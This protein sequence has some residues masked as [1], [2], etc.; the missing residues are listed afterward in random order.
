[1]GPQYCEGRVCD[2]FYSLP[3]SIPYSSGVIVRPSLHSRSSCQASGEGRGRKGIKSRFSGFLQPVILGTKEKRHVAPHHRSVDTEFLCRRSTLQDGNYFFDK[4][5]H[6]ARRLG[7]FHG[8]YGRVLSRPDPSQISEVSPI[9]C[10]RRSLPIS[11]SSVR[12]FDGSQSFYQTHGDRRRSLTVE[13]VDSSPV[14]RRLAVTSVRSESSVSRPGEELGGDHFFGSPSQ[15][16]EVG[17]GTV[18]G[19]HLCGNEF[20]DTDQQGKSSTAS[21]RETH[22]PGKAG[23]EPITDS[24]SGLP[25][26]SGGAERSSAVCTVGQTVLT[27]HS[28]LSPFA[29]E[30]ECRLLS[31]LDSYSSITTSA[32]GMVVGRREISDRSAPSTSDSVSFSSDRCQSVRMGCAPRTAWSHGLGVLVHPGITGAHQQPRTASSSVI[33]AAIQRP[34]QGTLCASLHGQHH[35]SLI[36]SQTGGDAFLDLVPRI[37]SPVRGMSVF[38]CDSFSQTSP[39]QT[40]CFGGRAFTPSSDPPFGVDPS[41]GGSR[42]DLLGTRGTDGRSVCNPAQSP[43][44]PLCLPNAGPGSL[45]SGCSVTRLASSESICVPSVHP[46]SSGIEED[47]ECGVS[48]SVSR[49]VLASEIVVQRSSVP[50]LRLSQSSASEVKPTLSKRRVDSHQP[51]DVSSS[52]LAVI[53]DA[54]RKKRFSSRASSLISEARRKSTT[55]VYNAKWKIFFS[56]CSA[57]QVDPLRPSMRRIADFLIFLFDVKKL[58]VSTIRGYRSML[59]HTLSFRGIRTIGTDVMLSDLIRSLEHKRPV[60]RSLTPKWDLSC[61]L[62]SLTKAPYEPL[63]QATLQ[64]VTWKTVF[65]LVFAS[66][67]RRSE[68]HAL[69][70]EDGCLRF[71]D[72]DGS[73]TLLSQAG[74][75]S[76]TQ[77]PSVA[78]E[79]FTIPSL[80]ANCGRDD[81]ERLL[82]PVRSLKFYLNLVKLLRGSRK[83]LFIPIKGKNE[84][85]AA[86]ISRWVASVIKK[87]YSALSNVDSNTLRIRA[88]ELR[89]LSTSWA[90]VN[91]TPLD[92]ILK[93][94][95]WR[96]SS[97]FS[98]FY[99]RSLSLQKD[100]LYLLGPLVASQ[101]VI[102]SSL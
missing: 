93:A 36:H 58:A 57:R 56:W 53:R 90:F 60:S 65:L 101:R 40:E 11:G 97:T 59:S 79:P 84:I 31:S 4:S 78:S 2:S 71:N 12:D 18:S 102:P 13:R 95:Y 27:T 68:I 99:L 29:L 85:S 67:K 87:A 3:S 25:V 83:R 50:P 24:G 44:P 42:S 49:S 47:Q 91:H 81:E 32:S 48:R 94:A 35:S 66:A 20:S 38:K 63:D 76:K 16:R 82:C 54:L 51:R 8:S 5:F 75:L 37:P 45:G 15:R 96:N 73:V 17:V 39:R 88:H 10:E 80:S 41:A 69:S 72:L 98:S 61:V 7:G 52:R 28:V 46:H 89:A 6:S 62:W 34:G 70:I 14:F 26:S 21:G 100:N 86:S 19:L 30:A 1:M 55:I 74:F 23:S 64:A 9:L 43:S 33:D 92:D 22:G 77:L